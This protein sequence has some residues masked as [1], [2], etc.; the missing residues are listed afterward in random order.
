MSCTLFQDELPDRSLAFQNSLMDT[1]LDTQ[2]ETLRNKLSQV[3][4]TLI[5][6]I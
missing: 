2:L 4:Y 3:S 5:L 1:H 6:Q